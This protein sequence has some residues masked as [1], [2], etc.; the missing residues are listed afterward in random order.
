V[1][2]GFVGLGNIGAPMARRLCAAGLRP[3]LYDVSDAALQPFASLDCVRAGSLAD[4]ASNVDV[5]GISV[6]D[7]AQLEAVL[8]GEQGLLAHLPAAAVVLVHSTVRPA[9]VRAMEPAARVR[10]IDLLDAPVTGGAHYAERGE[11]TTMVG[12]SAVALGKARPVLDAFSRKVVH[13]G[14]LGAGM[15]L[16][17]A[18]NLVTMLE[19]VAAHESSRLVERGGVD[20][21]L[22]REVMTENGNLTETMRR[23]LD[24]RRDGE[25][26]LGPEGFVDFQTR[27][28]QL[29]T[30]DL[31]V[32]L[33][34]AAESSLELPGTDA[35]SR[36]MMDVFLNRDA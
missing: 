16:K 11:L 10:G 21:A 5:V 7:D 29:V 28:G 35:A 15:V 25:R 23:F 34:I 20:P 31:E 22:L 3:H 6:R 33:A 19:L 1:R 32:A 27:M 30:K 26:Q 8:G 18:N 12:G 36:I 24:F 13:A 4:L 2:T 14:A 9:T 17:A